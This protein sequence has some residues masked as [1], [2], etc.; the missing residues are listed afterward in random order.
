MTNNKMDRQT[1]DANERSW[2]EI[3]SQATGVTPDESFSESQTFD[4]QSFDD[5]TLE[6][7]VAFEEIPTSGMYEGQYDDF[8]QSEQRDSTEAVSD[9]AKQIAQDSLHEAKEQ[10]RSALADQKYVA[11]GQLH[12]VADALRQTS[13]GLHSHDKGGIAQYADSA[14]DQVERFS[15]YLEGRDF[16]ELWDDLQTM[17]NRQPE[18]FVAGALAAGF[19]A[20]R[21]LRSSGTG[22]SEPSRRDTPSYGASWSGQQA[23]ASGQSHT[24]PFS[25]ELTMGDRYAAG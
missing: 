3:G 1:S 19:L 23:A 21:F 2:E 16:G 13:Q 15:S 20:G 17:A 11:A 4:N 8:Q 12:E 7:G 10:L 22:S 25:D 24:T 18:L 9:R 14:A 6:G 5:E